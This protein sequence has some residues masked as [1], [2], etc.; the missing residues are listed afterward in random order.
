M[1]YRIILIM[2]IAVGTTFCLFGENVAGLLNGHQYG[3]K[4]LYYLTVISFSGIIFYLLAVI[5]TFFYLKKKFLRENE[6]MIYCFM[7]LGLG[8]P[9]SVWTV[10]VVA[11]YWG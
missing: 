9:I 8:I 11:M 5:L 7:S 2:L 6:L 1:K 3:L 10:F 4:Q